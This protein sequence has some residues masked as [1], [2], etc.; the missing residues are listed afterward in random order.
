[1]SLLCRAG[2]REGDRGAEAVANM[3]TLPRPHVGSA[4][5]S[6]NRV[7]NR[8]ILPHARGRDKATATSPLPALKSPRRGSGGSKPP[9]RATETIPGPDGDFLRQSG[10][11]LRE[12][13][14][15]NIHSGALD[16]TEDS[17]G[18]PYARKQTKTAKWD[19]APFSAETDGPNHRKRRR[20]PRTEP[21][22]RKRNAPRN[23]PPGPGRMP[24]G[25]DRFQGRRRPSWR[26]NDGFYARTASARYPPRGRRMGTHTR[27]TRFYGHGNR[28]REIAHGAPSR[29]RHGR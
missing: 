13:S 3:A 28:S 29:R 25:G 9:G 22:R 26:R 15:C 21:T 17:H 4:P 19:G 6:E 12:G 20:N 27:T 14:N 1:M 10:G 2:R 8:S 18:R 7:R 23:R 11:I 24:R 5:H 16:G